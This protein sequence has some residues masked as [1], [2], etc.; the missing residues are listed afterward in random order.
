[1]HATAASVLRIRPSIE[2]VIPLGDHEVYRGQL[3]H[4]GLLWQGHSTGTVA[5]YRIDAHAPDARTVLASAPVP[6]TLEFLHPFGPRMVLA[7]GKHFDRR[8]GWLTYHSSIRFEDRP[9]GGSPRLLV[10]T[11]VMPRRVQVEQFAG[12]PGRMYFNDPGERRVI[13]WNGWW[14]RPV[15]GPVS[16]PGAML[17]CGRHMFVLER[18]DIHSGNETIARIDLVT[19]EIERSFTATRRHLTMMIDLEG[20]PWIA[21]PEAWADQVLLVDKATNRLAAT[22]P[23]PGT[24]VA[25]TRLGRCLVAFAQDARRAMFFDLDEDGFP[26]VAEWDLDGIGEDFGNV[27]SMQI[28]PMSGRMFLRSP[29]HPWVDGTV[30]AVKM[31]VDT[32]GATLRLCRAP[33]PTTRRLSIE[34][35]GA[36]GAA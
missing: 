9:P 25:I 33:S 28:D 18:N 20:L 36:C 23:V 11:R 26:L 34:P 5:D 24:P 27:R 13:R 12:A 15:G 4:G 29:Y 10:T 3:F 22:L 35:C 32:D 16:L 21:A 7:V 8:R 31:A 6:H 1:M 19:D 17:H 2:T 30:P 14:A